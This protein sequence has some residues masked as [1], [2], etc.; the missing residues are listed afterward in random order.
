[1][2]ERERNEGMDYVTAALTCAVGMRI[3]KF[4]NN[5]QKGDA[6]SGAVALVLVIQPKPEDS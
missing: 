6:K 5:V 4:T 1:V 2:A 3:M